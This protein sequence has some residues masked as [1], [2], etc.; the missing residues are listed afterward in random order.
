LLAVGLVAAAAGLALQPGGVSAQAAASI[1]ETG[2]WSRQP[3]AVP[4]SAFEVARAPDGDV[5]V[6]AFRI[7]VDGQVSSAQL[8][9]AEVQ[10]TGSPSL[11]ICATLATWTAPAPAPGMWDTR[12]APTCGS[13]PVR[14]A[15]NDV[16]KTWTVDVRSFLPSGQPTA[17]VMVVPALDESIT[18]PP[19][20]PAPPVG[21]P[22]AP[23]VTLPPPS[24]IP[25]QTPVPL[26]FTA[27]FSGA[28]LLVEG[29]A[30]ASG[31][32]AGDLSTAP[33]LDT[34]GDLG[35]SDSFFATPDIPAPSEQALAS[36]AQVEG[37]FPQRGDVGLPGKRG[38]NQPWGRLP[39]FTL[40]AAA[41]GGATTV[42]RSQL[43]ERGV[44][45]T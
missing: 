20:T 21:I 24:T 1:V 45:S 9:L 14:L 4:G 34:V 26:P 25:G 43:R 19:P 33:F 35:T 41:I 38:A 37:R 17:S 16:Q 22:V 27:S 12:P 3:A 30:G 40:L 32:P 23:P 18:V 15:H 31:S 28:Q 6:T 42:G 29:S 8:Q 10:V 2:W 13:T 44:L 7:R 11:Q 39:L 36:P 5:S